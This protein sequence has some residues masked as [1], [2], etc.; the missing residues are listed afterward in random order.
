MSECLAVRLSSGFGMPTLEHGNM[1]NFYAE[2]LFVCWFMLKK[3]I[4]QGSQ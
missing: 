2:D 4:S 3:P 1:H